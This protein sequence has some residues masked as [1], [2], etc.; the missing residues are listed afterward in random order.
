[1]IAFTNKNMV[2]NNCN[3]N[4]LARIYLEWCSATKKTVIGAKILQ[5]EEI[6]I[7]EDKIITIIETSSKNDEKWLINGKKIHIFSQ[8]EVQN[9]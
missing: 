4:S 1:M 8:N 6:W 3:N 5:S 9:V 2:H 7:K